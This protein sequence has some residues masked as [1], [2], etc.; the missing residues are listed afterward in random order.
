MT[1]A[2]RRIIMLTAALA[3]LPA[4]CGGKGGK[5]TGSVTLDGR[6]LADAQV[7]FVPA[8]DPSLPSASAMTSADGGF[9]V[10]PHPQTGVTLRPGRYHVFVS[11][12]VQ[13]DGTVPS[14][15]EAEML[16]AGGTLRNALPARYS[17]QPESDHGPVL[18]AEIKGGDQ[19]LAPF[20]LQSR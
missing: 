5:V 1:Q 17:N 6:P 12:H 15:E 20:A 8:D 10:R 14:G 2:S 9:E 19:E 18:T 7:Q 3:L 4:G 11:K 13:R 16:R